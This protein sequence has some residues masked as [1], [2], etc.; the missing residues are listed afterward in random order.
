M[1]K[2]TTTKEDN[3][4]AWYTQILTQCEMI[5][6]YDI[7]GCYILKP[8]TM[9]IWEQLRIFLDCEFK[10]LGVKNMYFPMFV[11]R[12]NLEKESSHIDGFQPESCMDK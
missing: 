9:E 10:K 2:I 6:Y 8:T 1:Q 5:E 11:K 3:F 7:S 12:E 4:S